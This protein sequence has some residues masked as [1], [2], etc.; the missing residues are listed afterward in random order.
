[1]ISCKKVSDSA[2]ATKDDDNDDDDVDVHCA[3]A[4]DTAVDDVEMYVDVRSSC[5]Q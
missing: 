5:L 2:A 4:A 1:M 3:L